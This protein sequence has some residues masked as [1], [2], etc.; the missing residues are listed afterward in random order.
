MV[1]S[2][3]QDYS[4]YI[5]IIRLGIPCFA[6]IGSLCE[7]MPVAETRERIRVAEDVHPSG[8]D[9]VDF[10]APKSCAGGL[11]TV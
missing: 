9:S 10:A 7:E 4:Q 8:H 5:V 3:A 1:S 6:G 11:R 2:R